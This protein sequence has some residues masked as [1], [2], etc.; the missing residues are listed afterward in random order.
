MMHCSQYAVIIKCIIVVPG[1]TRFLRQSY[2]W[3]KSIKE[4]LLFVSN[5]H[6]VFQRVQDVILYGFS[7]KKKH[8]KVYNL[9]LYCC[10]NFKS[11]FCCISGDCCFVALLLKCNPQSQTV[12]P[13][14]NMFERQDGHEQCVL[15]VCHHTPCGNML[16]TRSLYILLCKN[17]FFLLK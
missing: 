1:C 17:V 12:L 6:C 13:Q 16:S 8:A 5:V 3:N 14:Q 2:S 11:V 7:M 4:K 10:I 15:L 9:Y